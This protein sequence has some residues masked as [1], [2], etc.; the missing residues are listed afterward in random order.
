ME[1]PFFSLV[2]QLLL[3][4]AQSSTSVLCLTP[5]CPG[6]AQSF[7]QRSDWHRAVPLSQEKAEAP[8]AVRD[9]GASHEAAPDVLWGGFLKGS[10]ASACEDREAG[11]LEE[12]VQRWILL[13]LVFLPF[14]QFSLDF[15]CLPFPRPL[16]IP[17]PTLLWVGLSL[18]LPV[19]LLLCLH[20]CVSP[21]PDPEHQPLC[22]EAGERGQRAVGE[23]HG[24]VRGPAPP[25]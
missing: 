3:C 16:S 17:C 9:E 8:G 19:P 10:M 5:P 14:F 2:S 24:P 25:H 15:F 4:V 13:L 21:A 7:G 11:Y 12:L 23:A 22:L 6:C 1:L 20:R 18:Q